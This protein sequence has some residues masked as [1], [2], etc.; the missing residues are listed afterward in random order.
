[1]LR[2]MKALLFAAALTVAMLAMPASAEKPQVRP[3]AAGSLSGGIPLWNPGEK[4]V[5]IAGGACQGTCPVY[6]LYVFDDGRVIFV[7]K[8]YH[9][10]DRRVEE[11]D[12]A[13]C[14]RRGADDSRAQRRARWRHQARHLSQGS[15]DVDGHALG[16]RR[17]EHAHA[18]AQLRL[19]RAR[20][21]RAQHREAVHRLDR[22]R[23]LAGARNEWGH[24]SF[25]GKSPR[26][27]SPFSRTRNHLSWD[28]ASPESRRSTRSGEPLALAALSTAEKLG[29]SYTQYEL[30]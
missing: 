2:A 8:K 16:A 15:P 21:F 22:S 13:E 1:M 12:G 3:Y 24:S 28:T 23:A 14:V 4:F 26:R 11:A 25:P 10:Q 29:A 9:R 27:L 6:E 18:V 5:A 19:R 30:P 20:R 17:P 7:G